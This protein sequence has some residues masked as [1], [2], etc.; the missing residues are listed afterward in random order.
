[1]EYICPYCG[2]PITND[3]ILF[4]S[5]KT[6][7]Y[8]DIVRFNFL[9]QCC[10]DWP[11]E[12]GS[13]FTGLYFHPED[14]KVLT[15]NE[16]NQMPL[17]VE[18]SLSEGLTPREL[19]K[20]EQ[21]SFTQEEKPVTLLPTI[22][23]TRACPHCHCRLPINF[24]VVETHYVTMLGG[25]AAGKT[26]FLISM[27][28]QLNTQLMSRGM[29][30]IELEKESQTYYNYLNDYYQA[31]NGVTP[32]TPMDNT[33]FPFVFTYTNLSAN[34][35]RKC[36]IVIYDIAGEGMKVPEYL[37]QHLGIRQARTVMLILDV[38]MTCHGALYDAYQHIN[39]HVSA[40]NGGPSVPDTASSAT[41]QH[42]YYAETVE[43]FLASA[44]VMHSNLGILNQVKNVIA[45]TTKID[46]ALVTM[47]AMFQGNCLLPMD[48]GSAHQGSLD[49]SVLEHLQRD[50]NTFYANANRNIS[51]YSL[52]NVIQ[53]AFPMNGGKKV[54]V[55][56]LAVS[57]YTRQRADDTSKELIF[58]NGYQPEYAKHRIIEPFLVLL[59][60]IE[61]INTTQGQAPAA[62]AQPA[63]AAKPA[64]APKKHWWN[65]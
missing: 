25:R 51:N 21:V 5:D 61:M 37:L 58:S 45:I 49:L 22:L 47:P 4:V 44:V 36:N 3:S 64:K 16:E 15:R 13:E 18:V 35:I 24:G 62:S 2:G 38:N 52:T 10:D 59:A 39:Q 46:Q 41:L 34:P 48:L 6:P 31:H 14:V 43:S 8:E 20:S 9:K 57:T 54:N 50:I 19:M 40:G 42:D 33:L 17:T 26:A 53:N 12:S 28:H 11:F 32:P 30:T 65:R 1:M 60:Q 7:R 29:G 56:S 27:M 55:S 63:A 23:G